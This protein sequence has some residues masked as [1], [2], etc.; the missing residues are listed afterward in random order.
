[1][2]ILQINSSARVEGSNST[3]LANTVT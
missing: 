3:R 1:M 2:K